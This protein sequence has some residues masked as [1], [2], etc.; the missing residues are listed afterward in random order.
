MKKEDIL[1][2]V[3]A[4]VGAGTI[5][6]NSLVSCSLLEVAMDEVSQ[7]PYDYVISDMKNLD[8]DPSVAELLSA[9]LGQKKHMRLR[10][11]EERPVIVKCDDTIN[12]NQKHIIGEVVEYYNA[13]FATINEK[14]KFLMGDESSVIS[15]DTV[16]SV[17]KGD[18]SEYTY[19]EHSGVIVNDLGNG[20]LFINSSI[21]MDWD[22]I[23]EVDINYGYY[24][25]LHE[26]GHALGLGDVYY[27]GEEKNCD[28]IDMTTIMNPGEIVNH[29]YPNDYAILQALY[30]KEYEKHENYEDAIA[31]VKEKIKNYTYSFYY[32]Y[33]S[34][35]KENA[36]ACGDVYLKDMPS[37]LKW[38]SNSQRNSDLSY[39]LRF[40]QEGCNLVIKNTRGEILE[41]ACGESLE[42]NG[43]I[44]IKNLRILKASNYSRQYEE[45]I[46]IKLMLSVYKNKDGELVVRDT[47]FNSVK[48]KT[49]LNDKDNN[50]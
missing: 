18:L 40:H 4:I 3:V 37:S 29:L 47:M 39:E 36:G 50:R 6:A 28:Y 45:D 35:L 15:G 23:E 19:G 25:F 38:K 48:T 20:S 11:S 9:Q 10:M 7:K 24:V 44:F 17:S 2:K 13:V 46:G 22:A 31:T 30:S 42:I 16:I 33:A 8:V 27:S 21:V 34:F 41:Y 26:M 1:T 32:S 43:V 5:L 12:D 14:Y 49:Y